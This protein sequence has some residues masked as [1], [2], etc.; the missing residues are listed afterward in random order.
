ML[1]WNKGIL[2][3]YYSSKILKDTNTTGSWLVP[4]HFLNLSMESNSNNL[5]F[6]YQQLL[7]LIKKYWHSRTFIVMLPFK[8]IQLTQ[9]FGMH[10]VNCIPRCNSVSEHSLP[11]NLG[12]G[13]QQHQIRRNNANLHTRTL[14]RSPTHALSR[15][16][17]QAH[18]HTHSHTHK[19]SDWN[20]FG[21]N[22]EFV[23][24]GKNFYW[25]RPLLSKSWIVY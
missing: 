7:G 3:Y 18:P 11:H 25:I 17:P 16:H 10:K 6:I 24:S 1:T 15:A 23:H 21:G 5:Q 14:T 2:I 8:S 4:T 22:L 12:H 20:F 9:I 13:T 19:K